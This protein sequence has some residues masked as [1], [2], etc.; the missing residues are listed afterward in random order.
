MEIS[1]AAAAQCGNG[2]LRLH[3]TWLAW[4]AIF[5]FSCRSS[6]ALSKACVEVSIERGAVQDEGAG[7]KNTYPTAARCEMNRKL[8]VFLAYLRR[9]VCVAGSLHF[10]VFLNYSSNVKRSAFCNIST[11][12]FRALTRFCIHVLTLDCLFVLSFEK[13]LL[14]SLS[15]EPRDLS[16]EQSSL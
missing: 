16:H 12:I 2:I 5:G 9:L 6:G 13:W 11:I 3:L 4:E 10:V 14:T 7:K 1:P 8:V 15:L